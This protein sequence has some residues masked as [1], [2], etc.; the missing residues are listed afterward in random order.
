ML[1]FLLSISRG[2]D[3]VTTL[4]GKVAWWLTLVMVLIGF[5]NV[6]TRYV[7]RTIG[8]ALGGTEYIV[9]Q[10]YAYDLVFLLGAAYVFRVDGHVRVDILFQTL[11]NRAKAWVDVFGI[12]VFL[13][14]FSVLGIH[15]SGRYVATSWR[16]QEINMNAGGIPIYPIKTV[17]VVA[18][19]LLLV[20]ALSELIKHVAFLS[21]H[22]HSRSLYAAREA[23][24]AEA[25][26][27]ALDAREPNAG[28]D[29]DAPGAR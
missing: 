4:L 20:Q 7:G 24:N 17:I 11:S 2:I 16:Q 9:L 28:D 22:P 21:G 6:V 1:S 26:P 27:T 15:L 12:L 10:T 13:V 18:F 5:V 23:A 19:A 8:V 29:S 14:P 25:A 3:D